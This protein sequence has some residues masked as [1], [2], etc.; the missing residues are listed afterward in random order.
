MTDVERAAARDKRLRTTRRVL[1][2]EP[3]PKSIQKELQ[4]GWLR[5][6]QLTVPVDGC[7]E[8]L[9]IEVYIW[10]DSKLVGFVVAGEFLGTAEGT[11]ERRRGGKRVK[12][13]SFLAQRV[14]AMMYGGV[15]RIGRGAKVYGINFNIVPWHKHLVTST[16]NLIAHATW[17]LAQYDMVV[18]R[19]YELLDPFR[20]GSRGITAHRKFMLSLTE[21]VINRAIE[22]IVAAGSWDPRPAN[23][24]QECTGRTATPSGRGMGRPKKHNKNE[25]LHNGGAHRC[26]VCYDAVAKLNS[27]REKGSR[28][29][30]QQL[31]KGALGAV[32][33]STKGCRACR[34]TLCK[35]CVQGY[36]CPK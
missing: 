9:V 3:V 18:R 24:L 16:M 13:P 22:R 1:P 28:F 32:R 27:R 26:S 6:A 35:V 19:D 33:Y 4:P 5:R 34:V 14:H 31:M 12:V 21:D 25:K 20:S 30:Q 23:V 29:T 2:F 17:V 36:K 11:T 10:C 8:P 15:D 7:S